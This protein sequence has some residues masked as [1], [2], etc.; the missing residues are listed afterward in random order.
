MR[1][2][3]RFALVC[4]TLLLS[5]LACS[6]PALPG[7]CARTLDAETLDRARLAMEPTAE[8]QP[9]ATRTFQLSTA[10]CCYYLE[11]IENACVVYSVEPAGLAEIDAETGELQVSPD[12]RNG[13]VLTVRAD[14]EEG[15]RVVTLDVHVYTPGEAPLV[16]V[17]HEDVQF[18]CA[19]GEVTPEERIGELRFK[20]DGTFSVTWAPFEIYRDYWGAY[21]V[22]PATGGIILTVEGGNH[23]P[24]DLDGE[25]TMRFDESG[26]LVLDGV[27][28]GT[29][30]GGSA[31]PGCGHRFVR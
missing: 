7:R 20:A 14:V 4:G 29:P 3:L 11:P 26:R 15:R 21:A 6:L 27:W 9:G 12:T 8:M 22:D 10:E 17:W 23:A 1:G 5:A 2:N 18:D 19:G 31:T 16:G 13:A 25:G 24:E 28:L 30:H